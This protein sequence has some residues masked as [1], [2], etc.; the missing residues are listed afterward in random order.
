MYY[1]PAIYSSNKRFR[2]RAL[3]ATAQAIPRDLLRSLTAYMDGTDC[4]TLSTV[5]IYQGWTR[6]NRITLTENP[7]LVLTILD[8]ISGC[9]QEGVETE[10]LQAIMDPS[11]DTY[12]CEADIMPVD[13]EDATY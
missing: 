6:Y 3:H 4:A 5:A 10:K 13:Y 8:H 1:N 12:G 7:D 11:P 9:L 2:N